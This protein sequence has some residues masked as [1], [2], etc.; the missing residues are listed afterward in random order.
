MSVPCPPVGS[1]PHKGTDYP[2]PIGTK[3]VAT[4]A[5]K[6]VNAVFSTTHGNRVIIDHGPSKTGEGNVYTLYAHGS[7]ILVKEG[8]SV[9]AGE[10][11]MK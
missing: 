11:I 7:K 5:G 8:Q 2:V 1:N 9:K 4:A 6:V 3:V 10:E